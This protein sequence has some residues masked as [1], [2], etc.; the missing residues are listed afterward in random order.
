MI[1]HNLPRTNCKGEAGNYFIAAQAQAF[2]RRPVPGQNEGI[3][4]AWAAMG[5]KGR[6]YRATSCHP[7][8]MEPNF[9]HVTAHKTRRSTHIRNRTCKESLPVPGRGAAG[10]FFM[11]R[12]GDS[13]PPRYSFSRRP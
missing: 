5:M 4:P 7:H 6:E 10:L 9:A 12:R 3:S 13:N 2:K 8:G 11:I 1:Y